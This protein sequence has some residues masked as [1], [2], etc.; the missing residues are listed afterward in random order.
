MSYFR[1][2]TLLIVIFALPAAVAAAPVAKEGYQAWLEDFRR[3][4]VRA[5]ISQETL[6]AAMAEMQEPLQRIIKRDRSQAEFTQTTSDYVAARVDQK[7]IVEGRQMLRLYPTWLGRVERRYEVQRRFIIALWGLESRY[8]KHVGSYSVPQALATL[9]YDDRRGAY[10]RRELLAAL[11]LLDAGHVFL[12]HMK[13]SWAG[14]M[15]QC[16][17]MPTSYLAYGVDA[18]GGG[19]IDLYATLP[20]VFASAANY[21]AR[22]GWQDDQTWGRPV[23][24]PAGFDAGLAGLETRLPLPRWQELGVRRSN[25]GALPRRNLEASLLLPDGREGQAY[26]VYDNFRTLLKWNRSVAFAIAVGT[27][28]DALQEA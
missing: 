2:L 6:Q 10:F 23:Q 27:L 17:F 1:L 22:H 20:D 4:A 5:G 19:R 26:L 8:G 9:A 21:L 12:S 15:G 14:A 16:Q 24:L 3:D 18:D 28:A 13:G 11:K 25:G 7:R